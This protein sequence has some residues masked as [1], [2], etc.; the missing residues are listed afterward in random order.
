MKLKIIF[1]IAFAIHSFAIAQNQIWQ[2]PSASE[3]GNYD[4]ERPSSIN[5]GNT[6]TAVVSNGLIET[7]GGHNKTFSSENRLARYEPGYVDFVVNTTCHKAEVGLSD[8]HAKTS[9]FDQVGSVEYGVNMVMT[10]YGTK[11]YFEGQELHFNEVGNRYAMSVEERDSI[12]DKEFTIRVG[13]K[14]HDNK[15]VFFASMQGNEIKIDD[16]NL[17]RG[18]IFIDGNLSWP[19]CYTRINNSNIGDPLTTQMSYNQ[20]DLDL[21]GSENGFWTVISDITSYSINSEGIDTFIF[22]KENSPDKIQIK[23]VVGKSVKWNDSYNPSRINPSE[24]GEDVISNGYNGSFYSENRLDQNQN[25]FVSFRIDPDKSWPLWFG[26]SDEKS[27]TLTSLYRPE[28]YVYWNHSRDINKRKITFYANGKERSYTYAS[29]GVDLRKEDLFIVGRRSSD[30]NNTGTI[31]FQW[32]RGNKLVVEEFAV[33]IEFL[34]SEFLRIQ[35]TTGWPGSEI[36]D[37]S[38]SFAAPVEMENLVVEYPNCEGGNGSVSFDVV[39]GSTQHLIDWN[40]ENKNDLALGE[41]YVAKISDVNMFNEQAYKLDAQF[42]MGHKVTWNPSSYSPTRFS[43]DGNDIGNGGY[44]ATFYSNE[45]LY[46]EETWMSWRMDKTS[47]PFKFGMTDANNLSKLNGTNPQFYVYWVHNQ[48]D[49]AHQQLKVNINGIETIIYEKE[50]EIKPEDEFFF[51][52]RLNTEGAYEIYFKWMRG[53]QVLKDIYNVVEG[54]ENMDLKIDG[55]LQ[56]PSSFVKDIKAKTCDFTK[57]VDLLTQFTSTHIT[58]CNSPSN[59]SANIAIDQSNGQ[60]KVTL[61]GPDSSLITQYGNSGEIIVF[62][63]LEEGNYNVIIEDQQDQSTAYT[64]TISDLRSYALGTIATSDIKCEN[65]GF[66]EHDGEG[67]FAY[68]WIIDGMVYTTKKVEFNEVINSD[69]E[70]SVIETDK[71]NACPSYYQDQL[72]INNEKN[73]IKIH[74]ND[75]SDEVSCQSSAEVEAVVDGVGGYSFDWQITKDGQNITM[76]DQ[77]IADFYTEGQYSMLVDV[78]DKDGCKEVSQLH[79]INVTD[80]NPIGDLSISFI[81]KACEVGTQPGYNYL[82]GNRNDLGQI[83]GRVSNANNTMKYSI[84]VWDE[85]GNE[86]KNINRRSAFFYSPGIYLAEFVVKA[87]GCYKKERASFEV[88][89]MDCFSISEFKYNTCFENEKGKKK[90]RLQFGAQN[91]SGDYSYDIANDRGKSWSGEF[92]EGDL[93]DIKLPSKKRRYFIKIVDDI[94]GDEVNYELQI[95][96]SNLGYKC[97][98]RFESRSLNVFEELMSEE[99]DIEFDYSLEDAFDADNILIYPNPASD[100]LYIETLNIDENAVIS[101]VNTL[102]Q[103]IFM[104][105]ISSDYKELDI[106]QISKGVYFVNVISNNKSYKI[107]KVI[108][109]D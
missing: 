5:F 63:N 90:V 14:L 66:I 6:T 46:G 93:V 68:N 23:G 55:L 65:D 60:A 16:T 22:E 86:V 39:G 73:E 7:G 20:I 70:L 2:E 107:G 52:R 83:I 87:R 80:N 45:S 108:I 12:D 75:L 1:G 99:D 8:A 34:D 26:L 42:T 38:C 25:G 61:E 103:N 109:T 97:I 47:F 48:N 95:W 50:I 106:S 77:S 96:N 28:Y 57:V 21:Y 69:F 98:N 13:R 18:E 89:P 24:N 91:G 56:W 51:G 41:T 58:D 29:N 31:Y 101:L 40:G 105:Q 43:Y 72:I 62:N 27:T 82:N 49:L 9:Y 104:E 71:E 37:I 10:Q 64:F 102:G 30:L 17:G 54:A 19:V 100:K 44:N 11:F 4:V 67:S 79:T 88:K 81:D 74:F 32:W 78:T 94:N 84:V 92:S 33:D 85:N 76:L 53:G 35:G 3:I 36:R 59:A 15:W